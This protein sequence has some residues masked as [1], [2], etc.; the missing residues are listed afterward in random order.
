[1]F[2]KIVEKSFRNPKILKVSVNESSYCP[3]LAATSLSQLSP[4]NNLVLKK[5]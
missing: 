3:L 4:K 5:I 2:D 1:M